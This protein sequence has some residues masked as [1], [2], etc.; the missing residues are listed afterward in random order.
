MI[1]DDNEAILDVM[2]LMLEDAGYAVK[3]TVDGNDLRNMQEPLPDLL[4][5]DILLSGEDGAE[6]CK[7]LKAN[8]K[9]KHIP[10]IMLSA[11][12]SLEKIAKDCGAEGILAKPFSMKDMLAL[13]EQ[14]T[15]SQPIT[16]P[17]YE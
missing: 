10:V 5:L 3:T 17:R 14:H 6:L 11:N 7:S 8:S 2:T 13:V 4:F 1:T 16:P 9:T 15:T 12:G